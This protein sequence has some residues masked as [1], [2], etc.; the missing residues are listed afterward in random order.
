ILVASSDK[1]YGAQPR[2]PY[3]EDM[4]L[5]AVHP[6]DVSKACADLLSTSY[7]AVFEVPVSAVRCGNFFGPGDVNWDRLVPGT[8]RSLLPGER[9]IVRS[10]GTY[11]RDYLYVEDAALAYVRLA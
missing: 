1:A 4:A 5:L 2:L 8:A 10:D 11:T 7:H 9:P 6:Y 3:T